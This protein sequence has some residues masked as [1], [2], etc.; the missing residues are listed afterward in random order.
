MCYNISVWQSTQTCYCIPYNIIY[1]RRY[2]IVKQLAKYFKTTAGKI[3]KLYHYN[4]LLCN[5]LGKMFIKF[6]IN[7]IYRL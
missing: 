1:I 5:R 4:Y 6:Y 2:A 7:S 3:I